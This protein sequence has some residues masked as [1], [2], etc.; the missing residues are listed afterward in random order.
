MWYKILQNPLISFI[1]TKSLALELAFANTSTA[2][3]LVQRLSCLKIL[4]HEA[5]CCCDMSLSQNH[6]QLDAATCCCNELLIKMA[7]WLVYLHLLQQHVTR[8]C[9]TRGLMC[10]KFCCHNV[11][12]EV[13]PSKHTC[14]TRWL[15][16]GMCRS[17]KSPCV[18]DLYN[19]H[20]IT[21]TSLPSILSVSWQHF[22]ACYPPVIKRQLLLICLSTFPIKTPIFLRTMQGNP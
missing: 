8:A 21:W 12:H 3:T 18:T 2:K 6:M 14:R 10:V 11:S 9:H 16:T 5:T 1:L 15:V 17:N 7:S 13:A 19:S 20:C 4:S 22:P